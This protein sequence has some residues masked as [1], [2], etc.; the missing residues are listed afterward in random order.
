MPSAMRP[1][2]PFRRPSRAAAALFVLFA[3]CAAAPRLSLQERREVFDDAWRTIAEKH[4]DPQLGGV[5]WNAVRAR[6]APQVDA[7][8]DDGELQRVL[9]AMVGELHHSHVGV[10]P[11]DPEAGTGGTGAQAKAAGETPSSAATGSRGALGLRVAWLDDRVVVTH[12][13][14]GSAA[15]VAGVHPGDALRAVDGEALDARLAGAKRR[16]GDHWTGFVPYTIAALL[17]GPVGA[18]VTLRLEG[19]GGAA[20]D[21]VVRRTEPEVPPMELGNLGTLDAEFEARTL[22][23]GALYVR[24]APCFTPLQER[25]EQ[26]LAAH[27]DASGVVLDLRGNPGGLGALAMG[28][29]RQF[30]ADEQDLGTMRMRGAK[31][32]LHFRTNPVAAPFAGPLV[33]IVDGSTGST[34]EILAAGL[35]KI[36]RARVVGQTSMGAALP[37]VIETIAHGW[38][39]QAVVADF[40]LPDG[41][42]VEG[43]GAVPDAVV[44]ATRADYLAGRD[45]FVLAAVRELANAPKLAPAAAR[46][47]AG[48][49]AAA[50][51]PHEPCAMDGPMAELFARIVALPSSQKLAAAKSVRLTTKLSLMGMTGPSVTTV[52]APGRIHSSGSLP[53]VGEMLQVYD[54]TR[55]WSRNPFEGKR[56][57]DGEELAVLQRSGRLD[58]AAWREQY[59][60]MELVER[61]RAGERDVIVVRQT[62]HAGEGAPVLVWLDAS[63]LDA[64]HIETVVRSRMGAMPVA[65]DFEDYAEFAGARLPRRT[66]AKVGGAAMTTVLEKVEFDVEVDAALFAEP[67]DAAP[68]PPGKNAAGVR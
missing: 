39:V 58:P 11:P 16:G 41:T 67:A 9:Q 20:R 43:H 28:V 42:A 18:A 10:L 27:R 34:A 68:K 38:R 21:V 8:R 19:P 57:L 14:P 59:A 12:V 62:P 33:V 5:D 23:G 32:P 45:P 56:A 55:G 49:A 60:K 48:P 46:P 7:A 25:F 13:A 15:A 37:S 65:T 51:G 47:T 53:G 22:D 3:A 4:F 31:E 17:H 50:A 26:A 61:K 64:V 24:F 63:T 40:T 66:V 54:G 35:Q 6:F 1:P 2:I 44:T 29:A 36:G 52:Q 30:V